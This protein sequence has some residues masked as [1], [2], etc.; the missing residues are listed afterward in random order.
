MRVLRKPKKV[1]YLWY[2][3][4]ATFCVLA[5][6]YIFHHYNQHFH[7]AQRIIQK[8]LSQPEYP[9]LY[10]IFDVYTQYHR[11][12]NQPLLTRCLPIH[13]VC[14]FLPH[15]SVA[16]QCEI[17]QTYMAALP[18]RSQR[19]IFNDHV[20]HV[21]YCLFCSIGFP[22]L[23]GFSGGC[24]VLPGLR[25]ILLQHACAF[26]DSEQPRHH[27]PCIRVQPNP[28]GVFRCLSLVRR[29]SHHEPV[30]GTV[31]QQL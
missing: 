6:R 14:N 23:P 25:F 7:H 8:V 16:Y 27:A 17:N 20:H 18:S 15:I 31:L 13:L 19:F 30:D 21:L 24:H 2:I 5:P 9:Q 22:Y 10:P 26:D 11:N 3:L 28:C 12:Y 1:S 4:L 29:V